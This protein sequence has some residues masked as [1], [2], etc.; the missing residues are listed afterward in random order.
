MDGWMDGCTQSVKDNLIQEGP[1]VSGSL[2]SHS[3]GLGGAPP[4]L[5]RW[6]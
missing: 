3:S 1:L 5:L 6:W 2:L 4:Q